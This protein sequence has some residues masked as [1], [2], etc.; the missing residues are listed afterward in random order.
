MHYCLQ[1][2]YEIIKKK[3]LYIPCFEIIYTSQNL[4]TYIRCLHN[5]IQYTLSIFSTIV[6][7]LKTNYLL[8]INYNYPYARITSF[9]RT[10]N[11]LVLT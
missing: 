4:S 10:R 9:G 2:Y 8:V 3:F 6:F 5:I 11:V 1:R 7:Q